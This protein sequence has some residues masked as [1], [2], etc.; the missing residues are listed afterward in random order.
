MSACVMDSTMRDNSVQQSTHGYPAAF[1]FTSPLPSLH[2]GVRRCGFF[3][4]ALFFPIPL[5]PYEALV[6]LFPDSVEKKRNVF[7]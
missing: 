4:A 2:E 3:A 1:L 5:Q 7:N 6:A